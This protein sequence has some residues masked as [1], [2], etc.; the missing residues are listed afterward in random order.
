MINSMPT[1]PQLFG[2]AAQDAQSELKRLRAMLAHAEE[3]RELEKQQ[4]ARELH[5]DFGSALTALA[6]RLA[7]LSRQPAQDQAAAEQWAKAN[8]L[9]AGLTATARRIQSE[10]R[11][12]ALD[13]AGL[14]LALEEYLHEFESASGIGFSLELP[15]DEPRLTQERAVALFRMFQEMLANVRRHAAAGRIEVALRRAGQALTLSVSDNGGG[16]DIASKDLEATHGLRRIA[17]RAAFL[18]GTMQLESAPQRGTTV[19]V[20]LPLAEAANTSTSMPGKP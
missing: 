9:L 20:T 12:G 2:P 11:P 15:E 8:A 13:V 4:F 7:I 19:A 18:G 5:N 6:M 16:F 14:P 17:E 3:L 1:E 10:L